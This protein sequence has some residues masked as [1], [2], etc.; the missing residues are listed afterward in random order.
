MHLCALAIALKGNNAAVFGEAG[1]SKFWD[2]ER[3][4]YR[5]A[6]WGW[7]LLEKERKIQRSSIR[8]K[9]RGLDEGF[10]WTGSYGQRRR[11]RQQLLLEEEPEEKRSQQQPMEEKREKKGLDL[12]GKEKKKKEEK[13]AAF[14]LCNQQTRRGRKQK[15]TE[16][17]T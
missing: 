15:K 6:S 1:T 10:G 2:E 14:G 9:M 16:D 12:W 4:S 5:L 3:E 7:E 8:K 13:T 17:E 11:K